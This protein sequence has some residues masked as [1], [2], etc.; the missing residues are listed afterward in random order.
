M[1]DDIITTLES[2]GYITRKSYIADVSWSVEQ[3][4]NKVPEEERTEKKELVVNLIWKGDRRHE[5]NLTIFEDESVTSGGVLYYIPGRKHY[6]FSFGWESSRIYRD[7]ELSF[8]MDDINT[9]LSTKMGKE[10]LRN[11]KLINIGV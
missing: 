7:D 2:Y 8:L 10:D 11:L 1:I 9:E 4:F 5:L 3:M 6:F